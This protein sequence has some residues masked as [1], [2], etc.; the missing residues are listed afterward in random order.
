L[1]CIIGELNNEE[2][3]I[4]NISKFKEL[5]KKIPFENYEIISIKPHFNSK[6]VYLDK[7]I[8]ELNISNVNFNLI[9]KN[10]TIETICFDELNSKIISLERTSALI[11]LRLMYKNID[12]NIYKNFDPTNF[13]D[14]ILKDLGVNFKQ[15]SDY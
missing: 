4:I 14:L 9:N 2:N 3:L 11:N 8:E 15:D 6:K 5:M 7:L 12:L 10:I 1:Y 13:F